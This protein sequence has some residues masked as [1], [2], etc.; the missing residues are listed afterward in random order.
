M[1]EATLG[2]FEKFDKTDSVNAVG[3]VSST[4]WFA[5]CSYRCPGCHNPQ[6]WKLKSGEVLTKRRL[7]ELL[8]EIPPGFNLALLGGD[9]L[10]SQ[11]IQA[12]KYLINNFKLIYPE[13]DVLMWTGRDFNVAK[14][15][16]GPAMKQVDFIKTG[17]FD[18]SRFMRGLKYYGSTNQF[19]FHLKN[20]EVHSIWSDAEETFIDNRGGSHE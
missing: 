18:Q 10:E 9:P 3:K 8:R 11:N 16:L 14:G 7:D 5:G 20:G 13:A 19:F 15:L 4:I 6:T 17:T 12:T 2:Y 1:I